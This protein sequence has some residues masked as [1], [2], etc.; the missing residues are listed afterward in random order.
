MAKF[1][2][3]KAK[4]KISLLRLDFFQS[5]VWSELWSRMAILCEMFLCVISGNLITCRICV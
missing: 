5:R 4:T 3:V 2:V 1:L